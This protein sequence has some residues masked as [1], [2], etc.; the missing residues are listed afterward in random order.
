M[1][2]ERISFTPSGEFELSPKERLALQQ[3]L[4]V[5]P[6]VLKRLGADERRN[7]LVLNRILEESAIR[8][9]KILVFAC[10]VD[11]AHLIANILT[12][13]GV[14]SAA[15]TSH[16]TADNRRQ[17]IHNY[18]DSDE[19]QVLTN[20]GVLTTG[21]DAPCTNTAV[22]ARPTDSVVLFSQM[23]GRAARG[24]KAGGN[25]ECKV[26][27]I[28]DDLPGFRSIAEAFEYWDD[29]WV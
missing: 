4:D 9:N 3:G 19:L 21:F 6:S 22:I 12:V 8:S 14:P 11:H 7:L 24:T 28:V 1:I 15:I 5:P 20:Y 2:Y 17:L 23:V 29:I 16:T 27:T 25:K 18:R 10:S 13:K 26:I